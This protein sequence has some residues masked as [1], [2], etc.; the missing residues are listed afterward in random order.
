MIEVNVLFTSSINTLA[1]LL[2]TNNNSL[3]PEVTAV[4]LGLHVYGTNTKLAVS[5]VLARFQQFNI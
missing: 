2:T 4:H 1:K 5:S 3:S